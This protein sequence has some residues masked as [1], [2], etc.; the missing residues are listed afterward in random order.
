MT[1]IYNHTI[2]AK[3]RIFIPARM[4]D[5]LGDVFY[6]TLS[7]EKCLT[8]YTPEAW[9]SMREKTR[10][11]PT[12]TRKKMRPIFAYAHKCEPDSQGRIL[13]PQHLLDFAELEKN[14]TIVGFDECIEFWNSD[15]WVDIAT[16]ETT[17]EYISGVFMELEV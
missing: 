6:V 2:D 8:G 1:G 17:P 11:L 10:A 14:V 16:E 12:A 3:N 5:E 15:L 4:R 9:D 7:M 13:L